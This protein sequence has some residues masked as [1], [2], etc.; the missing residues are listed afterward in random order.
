MPQISNSKPEDLE[1]RTYRFAVECKALVK[2]P[3]KNIS[4]IEYAKQLA[5]S[6]GSVAANYIEANEAL[7][8][9]DF[10]MRCRICRKEAKETRLWLKLV[11]V[12]DTQNSARNHLLV[13]STELLKIFSAIIDKST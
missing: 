7:S 8:K 4:N 13:E 9:K 3:P 6:S 10:V 2:Q 1:T 5:R 11:D 12:I